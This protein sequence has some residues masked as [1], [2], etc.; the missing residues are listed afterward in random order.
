M[1]L[2]S[3]VF[4]EAE[5]KGHEMSVDNLL[6]QAKTNT[7]NEIMSD[8]TKVLFSDSKISLGKRLIKDLE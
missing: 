5:Q 3:R 8:E 7:L 2:R 6:I 4:S 1:V